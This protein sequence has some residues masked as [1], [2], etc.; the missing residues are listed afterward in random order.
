MREPWLQ[1]SRLDLEVAALVGA[2]STVLA[3]P[4]C[5]IQQIF[6]YQSPRR[7]PKV[8]KRANLQGPRKHEGSMPA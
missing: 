3:V 2:H 8:V 5:N 7:A 1:N 6:F 4:F